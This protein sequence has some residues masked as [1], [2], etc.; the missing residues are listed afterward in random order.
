MQYT[1]EEKLSAK[2][3]QPH[4]HASVKVLAAL[5]NKYCAARRTINLKKNNLKNSTQKEV[6]RTGCMKKSTL[7]LDI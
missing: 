2:C 1:V 6:G 3:S 4:L 5:C 7:Y